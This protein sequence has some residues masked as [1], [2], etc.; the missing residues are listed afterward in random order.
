LARNHQ[1]SGY[2]E[3]SRLIK[4]KFNFERL[5]CFGDNLNDLPMFEAADEKYAVSN[6]HEIV[7]NTADKIIESNNDNRVAKYLRTYWR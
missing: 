4:N 1:S 2:E 7:L 5:V 3:R 6:A